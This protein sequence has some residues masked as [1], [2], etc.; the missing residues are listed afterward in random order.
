MRGCTG[1]C[2]ILYGGGVGTVEYGGGEMEDDAG[3]TVLATGMASESG[4]SR[5]ARGAGG[6][7]TYAVGGDNNKVGGNTSIETKAGALGKTGG[8][9]IGGAGGETGVFSSGC[10]IIT[11]QFLRQATSQDFLIF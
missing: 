6:G 1:I 4:K 2:A 9:A 7:G 10:M 8:G 5:L 11:K 3:T